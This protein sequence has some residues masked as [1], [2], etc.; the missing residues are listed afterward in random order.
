MQ[1][2]HRTE[3]ASSPSIKNWDSKLPWNYLN[4]DEDTCIDCWWW[5]LIFWHTYKDQEKIIK[6]TCNERR[7]KRNLALYIKNPHVLLS[8][9]PQKL[10]LDPSHTYRLWFDKIQ[11]IPEINK[12]IVVRQLLK[13]SDLN[14]INEIYKKRKMVTLPNSFLKRAKTKK[15]INIFVA[16]SVESWE[17]IWVIMWID[18]HFAYKDPEWGS[19]FW[20]LAIDNQANVPWAWMA[21]VKFLI[22]FYIWRWRNFLDLSVMYNNIWAIWLYEKMWFERV[23][24]FTIKHKNIINEKLYSG[25][26]GESDVNIYAQIIID[27]A[28]KR[29]IDSEITNETD[30]S[31]KLKHWWKEVNCYE[32]LTDMT[33]AI[34]LKR[35]EDK[36][37]TSRLLRQ[38][39]LNTPDQ[40]VI[41]EFK[42]WLDF[43]KKYKRVVIKP[44]IWEQWQWI[45]VDIR[46]EI[47]FEKAF[48]FAKKYHNKVIIEQYVEWMDLRVIVINHKVEAWAIRRP[49][50]I[51]WTW[52]HTIKTLIQKLSRRRSSATGWESKIPLDTETKRCIINEWFDLDD[53]L[54]KWKVLQ[55]RKTA[56]LHTWWTIHDVTDELSDKLIKVSEEASYVLDIPVTWLDLLVPNVNWDDY[57]IIEANERPWLA[58]HEPQPLAERFIDFLF[59]QTVK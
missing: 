45:S 18:H 10:F 6:D 53:I 16:E 54:E 7:W 5:N 50:E 14:A 27:E 42:N 15:C 56:N 3:R 43:F 55:I 35:C 59:P 40:I 58:N 8:I 31:F 44:L 22:D 41:S 23:P 26:S 51:I 1:T 9:A 49:P 30:S 12:S 20:A 57:V 33:S 25:T 4:Y 17:I 46:K 34:A 38:A 11:F 2:A 24:V 48:K 28:R 47:N 13:E 37:L 29:G 52:E 39:W 36:V 21:L 32:S 19:S